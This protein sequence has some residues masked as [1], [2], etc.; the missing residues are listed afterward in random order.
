MI[1]NIRILKE[2][3]RKCNLYSSYFNSSQTKESFDFQ[4]E[5]IPVGKSLLSDFSF[6]ND[7]TSLITK[8]TKQKT[9]WF[10]NKYVLDIG[11]GNGRFSYGF[12]LLKAKLTIMDQSKVR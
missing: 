7:I 6:R 3:L 2:K 11:C 4:W 10:S 1:S 5:N 8:Y 12:A 9:S